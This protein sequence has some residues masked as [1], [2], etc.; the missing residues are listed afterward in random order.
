MDKV[1]DDFHVFTLDFFVN[2]AQISHV[3]TI[4]MEELRQGLVISR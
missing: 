3:N 4:L 2:M 1:L